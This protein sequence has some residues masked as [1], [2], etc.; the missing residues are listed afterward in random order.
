[1][2][3]MNLTIQSECSSTHIDTHGCAFRLVE[4]FKIYNSRI[5]SSRAIR[6]VPQPEHCDPMHEL[7]EVA[8]PHVIIAFVDGLFVRARPTN[9]NCSL[10]PMAS[11]DGLSLQAE[12]DRL[13]L[14]LVRNAVRVQLAE[15]F[16]PAAF[17]VINQALEM[18]RPQL[19]RA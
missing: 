4:Y 3:N 19:A 12:A 18:R 10:E 13:V 5:I 9:L 15:F 7:C 8:G 14:V 17:H 1:M 6:G 11:F 16:G 2:N